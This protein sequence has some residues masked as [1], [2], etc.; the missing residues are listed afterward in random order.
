LGLI[1]IFSASFWCCVINSRLS[2]KKKKKKWSEVTLNVWMKFHDI[3]MAAGAKKVCIL[4]VANSGKWIWLRMWKIS[5]PEQQLI[6][7]MK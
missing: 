3:D 1:L 4:N 2:I 6:E 5:M 7:R